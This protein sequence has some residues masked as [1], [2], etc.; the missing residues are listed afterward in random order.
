MNA[1]LFWFGDEQWA[2]IGAF[3]DKSAWP[4]TQG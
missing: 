3:A 1:D 4:A 2:K